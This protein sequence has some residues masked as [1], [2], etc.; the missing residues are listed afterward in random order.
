[1][2][3]PLFALQLILISCL[4]QFIGKNRG[5]L[6]LGFI[7]KKGGGAL[8]WLLREASS[9]FMLSTL[10]AIFVGSIPSL[11]SLFFDIEISNSGGQQT[12]SDSSLSA[13]V[14]NTTDSNSARVSASGAPPLSLVTDCLK[15]LASCAVPSIIIGLGA[16]LSHGPGTYSSVLS[17]LIFPLYPYS[18]STLIAPPF[19]HITLNHMKRRCCQDSSSNSC[20]CHHL[21]PPPP[22]T[23]WPCDRHGRL[24]LG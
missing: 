5:R 19:Y 13:I 20:L 22:P 3:I 1:M 21:S 10:L 15:M 11:N 7:A 16:T 18:P 14:S 2:P 4:N 6:L 8:L 24:R 12:S 23:P 17:G 9:P